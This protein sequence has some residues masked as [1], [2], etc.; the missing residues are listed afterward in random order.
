MNEQVHDAGQAVRREV[1]GDEHVDRS[2]EK[3][4]A[5]SKPMQDLVTEYCWGTIWTR[6]HLDRRSRSI[7]NLGILTALN[8]GR[9][10]KLH[11]RGA[12]HNGLSVEEIREVLLQS[13]VYCGIPA[14]LDA[15]SAAESVLEE[16][17]AL[18]AAE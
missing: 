15:F 14:A 3:S 17:G 9:E 8:R 11:V 10:L 4:T 1:L 12:L 16:M 13:A 5:C 6:D 18:D 7:L 2:M